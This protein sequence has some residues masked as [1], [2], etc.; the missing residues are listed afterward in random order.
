MQTLEQGVETRLSLEV[1]I[2]L[3]ILELP[4][5]KLERWLEFRSSN[6]F[7]EIPEENSLRDLLLQQARL[8]FEG[9]EY[10]IAEFIINSLDRKGFLNESVKE[11]SKV[12]KVSTEEVERVRN[13]IKHFEPPGCACYSLRESLSVQLEELDA[14]KK[15]VSALE[16]LEVAL[17]DWKLF[18]KVSGLSEEEGERLK[19]LL[20]RTSSSPGASET[21]KPLRPDIVV[22]FDGE[23]VEVEVFNPEIE[24][25][26]QFWKMLV[27]KRAETLKT[28]AEFV[29]RVQKEFLKDGKTLRPLTMSEV[30]ENLKLHV[31]TV[32]RA[33][34]EKYVET[35]FGMFPFS[36]FFQ[37][38]QS[39]L[40]QRIEKAII[41]IVKSEKQPLSDAQISEILLSKGLKVSRRTV[42]KIRQELGIPN[43]RERKKWNTY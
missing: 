30:A 16:H 28:I 34:K 42:T 4:V 20:K 35:P 41:E 23:N 36:K 29:F 5:R 27:K 18:L 32:S 17:K 1:L 2:S 13:A 19:G 43:S 40:S 14:P 22:F 31:S 11:I 39:L 3:R 12:L 37:K 7:T 24:H 6:T 25:L 8:E 10:E 38:P 33:V 21:V 9:K 26:N 15:L